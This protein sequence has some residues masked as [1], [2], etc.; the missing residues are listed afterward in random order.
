MSTPRLKFNLYL[1][2]KI[3]FFLNL[4]VASSFTYFSFSSRSRIKT[5]EDSCRRLSVLNI[6]L[7]SKLSYS[8][9]FI[10]NDI[11]SVSSSFATNVLSSAYLI[12]HSTSSFS[13]ASNSVSSASSSVE[14]PPQL[15]PLVF[16]GFF[17]VDDVPYIHVRNKVY[18]EG[19]LLLGHPVQLISPDVVQYR[20]SFFKVSSDI[21]LPRRVLP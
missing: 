17:E 6:D 5:L 16:S 18:K 13:S 11:F 2:F 20:D 7:L 12:S 8:V 3:S 1:I 4:V 15:P 21:D 19:D 10:T 14:K 9:D